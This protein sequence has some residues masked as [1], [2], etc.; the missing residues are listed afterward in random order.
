MA[1]GLQALH[2]LPVASAEAADLI[3]LNTG[4]IR[5]KSEQKVFS[6]LGSLAPL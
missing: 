4:A 5:E 3:L 2:F 1:A 6:Y